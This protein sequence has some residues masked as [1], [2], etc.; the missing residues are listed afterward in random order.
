MSDIEVIENVFIP[1]PDGARLAARLW[2]PATRPA[3]AVVEYMPYRKR[4]ATRPRDAPIH[5]WLAAHGYAALRVD[6]RG[7]GDSDGLLLQEFQAQEQDDACAM[8]EWIA[9][10]DWCEGGVV[11]LGK[12][13][14]AFAGLMAAMRQPPALRGIV[15]VCGGDDRYD[16]SLHYTGGALL[17]E[18]L[19]WSDA[20]MLLNMRPPDPEIVGDAWRPMWHARLD[21]NAPWLAEWL[22]HQ[23]R[24]A[25][26]QHGS[27]SDWPDAIACPV[28]A[29][30]GWADYIS[31][32]VP[33][34]MASLHVPRWGIVGPW[35]HHYPH[36][37]VPGPAIGFL[38]EVERFLEFALRD[39]GTLGDEPMLRAWIADR[40]KP[41]VMHAEQSGRW[42]GEDRWPSLRIDPWVLHLNP[43]RLDFAP[44]PEAALRHRSPQIVGLCAPEWLSQGVPGEAP[45]DQ[46]R[47]DGM[48]L[49]FDSDPL[50][51]QLDVLGSA[52]LV[53][54]LAVDRPVAMV[55]ARL[56]SVGPDGSS[57]LV[58]RGVLN[59][60]RRDSDREP[61]PMEPGAR[62][63][64]RIVL[65]EVGYAFAPG[66]RIRVALSTS[67]W[68]IVWPSPEPV[69]LTLFTGASRLE[70]PVR[71]PAEWDEWVAFAPPEAGP[72]TPVTVLEPAR[73]TRRISHDVMT[74]MH[75]L[76]VEGEGGFL[77][78]G[79]KWRLE[80]TGTV[81]GHAIRKRC[82]IAE[83][84]PLS[85]SIEIA[86]EMEFERAD[87]VVGL[88]T[89][90]RLT[91]T[92]EEFVLEATARATEAGTVVYERAWTVREK[93]ELG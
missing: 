14:G 31:C 1:M 40:R 8:I 23:R 64:V 81:L 37:G 62:V 53:L 80:E 55:A 10:Q 57:L 46:R 84:D 48:S 2:L 47:D 63:T 79:R 13:W 43:G 82:A 27:V 28:L 76:E 7:A 85:A 6:M 51:A 87:W 89:T 44:W 16:Q 39:G 73:V 26:W 25:F 38:H 59:L 90:T 22:R 68:P 24:D 15:V 54:E 49:C 41:G 12:S 34:L 11:M 42:V 67:C 45:M 92:A 75:V 78:P 30:G 21:A 70:L 88:A 72:P 18:T 91:G 60:T 77:G 86:Q 35:G 19:W 32:S 5:A 4:D 65:P 83:D 9:A 3:A 93:R 29:V 58:S 61:A 50:E 66:E 74:G 71:P 52:E 17:G 20:M 36:D 56:C 69:E 33:R